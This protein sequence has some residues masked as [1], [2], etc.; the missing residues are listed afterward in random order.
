M[1]G[2]FLATAT[3]WIGWIA[4]L[5]AVY[6]MVILIRQSLRRTKDLR[7]VLIVA[8]LVLLPAV[9]LAFLY[10][11]GN[12]L[13]VFDPELDAQKAD[14]WWIFEIERTNGEEE[15]AGAI[16]V[17]VNL[18]AALIIIATLYIV[19]TVLIS[20][21]STMYFNRK[22][23]EWLAIHKALIKWPV[24]I[25]G[26]LICLK[27]QIG[28]ILLGT[29][30]IVIGLG[31]VLKEMLENLFTGMALEMEGTLNQGDWIRVGDSDDV[32]RVYEKS[33]RVTKVQ[34]LNDESI[35]IPNRLLGT[36][37][38]L[39]FNKPAGPHA[40]NLY[41]GT[42]YNDPPVKVKEILR[43]I[44][45]REP[46]VLN[47]PQ[48]L[49]RTIEYGDFAINFEMKFWI[50]GYA[51]RNFIEDKIM[52]QIWYAFKYY[53][54]Q[55]PFPIRT[56][57]MKKVEHLEAESDAITDEVKDKLDFLRGLPYFSCLVQKDIEYMALNSFRRNYDVGE[58]VVHKNEI[59]DAL[60]VVV[61]GW[62]EALLP[63]G[64]RPHIEAG[65]YFGEMGLLGAS[66]RTVDVAA[67][68]EG[69]LVM[70]IDKHCMSVLFR[71]YPELL[72]HFREIRDAR[73]KELPAED[74]EETVRIV[75]LVRKICLG[76]KDF[77][78]PW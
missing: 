67:G 71:S 60:Y 31:L 76:M 4:V 35:T 69:A 27:I 8:A 42:S 13:G 24:V 59:G 15:S 29:S 21:A 62:C 9:L 50:R 16:T 51:R 41:V 58:R 64:R 44:L 3:D 19:M 73:R 2:F 17:T 52:T 22:K 39:N 14:Q 45:I 77:F 5:V 10:Y 11:D 20:I 34:T 47:E 72:D 55:I 70:R 43:T 63:D 74:R 61:N 78:R 40:R 65:Q 32:G 7:S 66:P 12:V 6:F 37:K 23:T 48:P 53:G 36:E 49:V 56:L 68:E 28:A 75:G 1:M 57:H 25:V 54:V 26:C 33:W 38:I 18:L 46:E 30:V